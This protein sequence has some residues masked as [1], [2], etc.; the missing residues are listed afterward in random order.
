I[1][2]FGGRQ[3]PTGAAWNERMQEDGGGL[4]RLLRPER[5]Q[6]IRSNVAA[7][8]WSIHDSCAFRMRRADAQN[9]STRRVDFLKSV[10]ALR[11]SVLCRCPDSS[12]SSQSVAR[13]QRLIAW[14]RPANGTCGALGIHYRNPYCVCLEGTPAR[15]GLELGV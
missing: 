10:Q 3:G 11:E 12:R 4:A 2:G 6:S 1:P 5:R 9:A 8:A 14:P 13:G 15:G 7:P